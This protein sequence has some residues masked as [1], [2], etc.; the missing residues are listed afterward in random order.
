MKVLMIIY[1]LRGRKPSCYQ[2]IMSIYI[3]NNIKLLELINIIFF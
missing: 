3:Y 2:L 1:Q